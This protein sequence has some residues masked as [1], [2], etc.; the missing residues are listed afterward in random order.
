[1]PEASANSSWDSLLARR[2]RRKLVAKTS[3]RSMPEA[4]DIVAYSTTALKQQNLK[5]FEASSYVKLT[6][7]DPDEA[8]VGS[9]SNGNEFDDIY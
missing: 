7:S 8:T 4:S 2:N 5:G 6:R 1:M 3:R 9:N